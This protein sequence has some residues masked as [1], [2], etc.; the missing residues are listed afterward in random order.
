MGIPKDIVRSDHERGIYY[1]PLYDNTCEFLR[2]EIEEDKLIKSFDTSTEY[3]T[4]MWKDK[5]ARKRIKSLIKNDRL[6]L[7]ETLFY[8]DICF[9]T[10]DEAKSK[11]LAAIGR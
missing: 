7:D 1:S 10:W 9:M 8:D 5:Y 11:Y 6:N 3:L 4:S 2:G